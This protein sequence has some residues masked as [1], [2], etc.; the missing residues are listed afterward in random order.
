MNNDN[1]N[2]TG[3]T[4]VEVDTK[5]SKDSASIATQLTIK[6]DGMTVEDVKALAQQALIVKLQGAWRKNGIP[7][8]EHVVNAADYKVG[9]RAKREPMTAEAALN[10]LPEAER[11][12]LVRSMMEKMGLA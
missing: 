7:E 12:A 2:V 5:E 3:A 9:T 4:N 8:G 10:K 1:D 6:W 11:I